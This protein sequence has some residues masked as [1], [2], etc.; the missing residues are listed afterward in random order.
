MKDVVSIPLYLAIIVLN[1][2][3]I[4]VIAKKPAKRRL[5]SEKMLLSLGIGDLLL[6]LNGVIGFLR[7]IKVIPS[8]PFIITFLNSFIIFSVTFSILHILL[9]TFDRFVSV[10]FPIR[11]RT[12]ISDKFV[13]I[14]LVLIWIFSLVTSPLVVWHSIANKS[15]IYPVF[16]SIEVFPTLFALLFV[17]IMIYRKLRDTYMFGGGSCGAASSSANS[18]NPSTTCTGSSMEDS[19]PR[20]K[21]LAASLEKG[22]VVAGSQLTGEQHT[23]ADGKARSSSNCEVEL[24]SI[25]SVTFDTIPDQNSAD[26]SKQEAENRRAREDG[27]LENGGKFPENTTTNGTTLLEIPKQNQPDLKNQAKLN[28]KNYRQEHR[29]LMLGISIIISFAICFLPATMTFLVFIRFSKKSLPYF[30]MSY[31]FAVMNSISNPVL[32]FFYRYWDSVKRRFNCCCK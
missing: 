23:V 1:S 2:I 11:R 17:Y 27:K 30:V 18:C 8:T 19:A 5:K 3:E 6:G 31:F 32:Y 20:Q 13:T 10:Y 26:V 12:L 14:T 4:Y 22:P 21:Q 7:E 29:I 9:L 16:L 15:H 28:K 25:S 24:L